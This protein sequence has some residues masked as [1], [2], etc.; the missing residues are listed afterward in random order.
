MATLIIYKSRHGT[1]KKVATKLSKLIKDNQVDAV[2]LTHFDSIDLLDY[3]TI[4]IG[5]SIHKG[6]ISYDMRSFMSSNVKLLLTKR[7]GLYM[8]CMEEGKKAQEQ[9]DNAYDISLRNASVSN[10]I[11]GGEFLIEQMNFIEKMIIKKQF[12]LNN[13]VSKLKFDLIEQ[14][15]NEINESNKLKE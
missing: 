5:A 7:I 15:A 1:T 2:E 4:I 6:K 9:F 10:G 12:S 14:F 13:S 3:N 11:F 8:C